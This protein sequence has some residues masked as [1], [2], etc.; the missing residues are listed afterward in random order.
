[1]IRLAVLEQTVQE[2]T[3]LL[4]SSEP[5]EDGAFCLLRE[6]KGIHSSRLLATELLLPPPGAWER[7]GRGVLRPKAQWISAAIS[8][9]IRSKSGL[10][11][12]HSHPDPNFPLG[13]SPTDYEAFESLGKHIGPILDGPFAAAVVHPLGWSGVL[14]DG[15]TTEPIRQILKVGR[16][17]QFLSPL[18]ELPE[19]ALDVRQRDA[20][21]LVHDRLRNLTVGLVG[22]GG[23]G[24]PAAEQLV[25]MGVGGLVIIDP[26]RVDTPSNV[27][28]IFG[29]TRA[30]VE[31]PSPPA[32][33]DVARRHLEGLGLGVPINCIQ[34]D[35]RHEAVFR[36]LL[37]T[38]IVLVATDN[39]GSRAVVNDLASTYLLP[40]IDVGV[41]AGS[42]NQNKLSG[43]VAEVRVLTPTTP[44]LW[45]RKSISGDVIR[46]ENMP[47]EERKKLL[48]EGYLSGSVG[49]PEPSVVA[50]TVLGSGL[51]T[52]A[53][54]TTLAEE[55]EVAPSG[56]WVDGFLGDA[57]E[58]EPKEPLSGCRCRSQLGLGDTAPPPFWG[59]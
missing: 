18:K 42:K 29:S 10:L 11:F 22:Y 44:C 20:L 12:V 5:N 59:G 16:T 58:L 38:D 55:G 30:D 21:G 1:M 34:G 56:Y 51:M 46:A 37:D 4:S 39:H 24:S 6:A 35:V 19:T 27:R 32:K 7:Q 9:A 54:L 57:H 3:W 25:R 53:L 52:C 45:C 47:A 26:E 23:L 41:R 14:W 49:D 15:T 50:L 28:R 36:F 31:A 48:D 8:C 2:L 33:V 43:L 17:L 13:F 40:V